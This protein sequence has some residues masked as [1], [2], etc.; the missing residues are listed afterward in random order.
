MVNAIVAAQ[1][2]H[3]KVWVTHDVND[4]KIIAVSLGGPFSLG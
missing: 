3:Q 2:T 1:V 4:S